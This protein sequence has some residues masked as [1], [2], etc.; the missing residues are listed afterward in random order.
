[1]L[2]RHPRLLL[3]LLHLLLVLALLIK[4]IALFVSILSSHFPAFLS[5]LRVMPRKATPTLTEHYS[6][7]IFDIAILPPPPSSLPPIAGSAS[8]P[9]QIHQTW[10]TSNL[11]LLATQ[12]P[13]HL[14]WY[15][16]WTLHN[17]QYQRIVR[18]DAEAAAFVKQH[19]P[20]RVYDAY[21]RLPQVVQKTDL[22]RYLALLRE[23]GVYT[24]MDT[25]CLKEIDDWV[26]PEPAS[27]FDGGASGGIR[28]V[29]GL[30][31]AYPESNEIQIAQFT[32]AG[33]AGHPILVRVVEQ[34]VQRVERATD[35][36]LRDVDGVI[37]LTGPVPW[38]RAVGKYLESVGEDLGRARNLTHGYLR[39][40][41]VLVLGVTAFSA[42]QE[43]GLGFE[44]PD[45]CVGH[46][47]TGRMEG[48][49]KR[50]HGGI[51]A[52]KEQIEM[53]RE[54]HSP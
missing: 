6:T 8:I 50:L 42:G 47:G 21:V 19:F 52:L 43:T 39:M 33:T 20:G 49:W 40:A 17:P 48:G 35:A 28:F 31:W 25:V 7:H 29:V 9:R 24:D 12:H 5:S 30:E 14:Q 54:L 15:E 46:V 36:E 4:A 51:K 3:R 16:T 23:G 41:D 1:M 18:D 13:Q 22:Y 11:T 44:H 26:S 10:K 53:E 32:M 27:S 2:L 34:I 37:A 38:T 45:V